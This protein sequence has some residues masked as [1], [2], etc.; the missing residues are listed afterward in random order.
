MYSDTM[1]VSA[2][3]RG[4]GY[5]LGISKLRPEETKVQNAADSS[6]GAVSFMER[7][8]N[9]TREVGQNSRRGACLIDIDVRH[10]DVDKFI[11][12]KENLTKVTGANISIFLHDDFMKAVEKDEDYILR[13]P[14][15]LNATFDEDTNCV[16]LE[17]KS[18]VVS[19]NDWGYN[20]IVKFSGNEDWNGWSFKV[21]KAKELWNNIIEQAKR[22]A[23]PGVFFRDRMTDYSPSNVYEKYFEDGTNACGEQ[24]MAIFDSCRLMVLNL[25]SFVKDP[26]TDKA[27]ID[28]EQ[29]YQISYEQLRLTDDLVDLEIEHLER[30][31]NKI[32]SDPEPIE[33]KQIELTLWENVRQMAID[34]RR[35]GCGITALGDML[36]A[37]GLK[38]DSDESLEVVDKIMSTKM[39]GELDC[40]IDLA[41]LRGTFN[42]WDAKLEYIDATKAGLDIIGNNSFY[43]MLIT[44]FNEQFQR[45]FKYGRRNV[46]FST[47]APCGSISLETQ[48]T[49]GC[50]PLFMPFYMR[51]KKVNPNDKNVI[52]DFTDQNGDKWQEFP[53]LHSKFKDW[54]ISILPAVDTYYW[55]KDIENLTNEELKVAFE[56]SPWYGSTANDINWQKRVE[57]QAVLQKYTSS[58]ISTTLNLPE[59]ITHEEVSNIYMESWRQGLKGQTIY[60]QNSR[61][62]VLVNTDNKKKDSFEYHDAPKR[63]KCLPVDV[64]TTVSKGTKWNVIVGLFDGK[65]YEVFAVPHFTNESHLELCKVAKGRYDLLKNKETYSE[66]ITANMS[67]EEDVVTRLCSA[68]LRHG[69]DITYLVEQL[70][71]SHGDITSFSKAISRCLKKYINVEKVT[72]KSE[73]PECQGELR[74]EEGCKKCS[75]GFSAC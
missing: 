43:D 56:K 63:P 20:H 46:N 44:D 67:D 2:A 9:S 53:V 75:C 38:Y 47:I 61:T 35:T 19:S 74:Y 4:C 33:E 68:G 62:G 1:L 42:N 34:G 14:C 13:F 58:A 31:I 60:V 69:A 45:M 66:D 65:P 32:K 49:S 22:N 25:F 73:C 59:T 7:F 41:I 12:I 30:I 28:Y 36:A 15:D 3:K 18:I 5:G 16:V 24:P 40:T 72:A 64:F 21:I 52:I 39:K 17:K 10:P 26:F 8:S 54:C 51:R 29:L 37:L 50:E 11:T 27:E 6:T 48:T 23:E 57:M 55:S 71:K 70:G